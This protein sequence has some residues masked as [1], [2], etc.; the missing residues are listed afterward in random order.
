MNEYFIK[1][2]DI[3]SLAWNTNLWT[4]W[5]KCDKSETIFLFFE[6]LIGFLQLLSVPI[7]IKKSINNKLI[8]YAIS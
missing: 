1:P 6:Q 2:Y 8:K 3:M 5:I 4:M 7:W